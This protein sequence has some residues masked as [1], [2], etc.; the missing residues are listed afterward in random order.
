MNGKIQ[1]GVFAVLW[2]HCWTYENQ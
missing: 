1:H 2:S